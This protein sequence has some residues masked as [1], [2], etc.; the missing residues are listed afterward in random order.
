MSYIARIL[1]SIES[2][3]VLLACR[4]IGHSTHHKEWPIAGW[5]N[6][7]LVETWAP[8]SHCGRMVSSAK[9]LKEPP[10]GKN[11]AR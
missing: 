4:V 2:F 9:I 8:C 5:G 3:V 6:A 1:D 7:H 11:N 10:R